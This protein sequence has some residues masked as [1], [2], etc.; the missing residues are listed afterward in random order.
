MRYNTA[1]REMLAG[2]RL[3]RQELIAPLFVRGGIGVRSEI[4]SMPGQYQFSVDTA[5]ETVRRW[6]DKGLPAVLLFGVTDEKHKDE[7]GSRAWADDAPVQTLIREIKH[8]LPDM[9]VVADTCLCEYTSHGHCGPLMEYRSGCFDVDNDKAV[10]YLARTAV[11]QSRAGADI[12]APSAMMD[13]QVA[14]IRAALDEAGM[15]RTA[16]M[17]YSVKFASC[18]YGPFRDAAESPPKSGDRKSYQMDFRSPRQ[19]LNELR[20]DESHGADIVMVKP[21]ATYLDVIANVRAATSLPLAAYHVS[22]EYAQIK[23]AAQAG[24]LDERAAV[25]ETM[26]AIKRAGADIIITYYAEELADWLTEKA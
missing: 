7:S 21:A 17:S 2:V 16:I 10:E 23:F 8:V 22:G 24:A 9:L 3:R 15:I 18:M 25:I 19:Y 13:N 4:K 6:A 14:A 11:S 12:V 26:S 20:E 1:L 5:M